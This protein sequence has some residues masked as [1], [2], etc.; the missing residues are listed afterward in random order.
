MND[1]IMIKVVVVLGTD[2]LRQYS[3]E[4]RTSKLHSNLLAALLRY[5]NEA[6]VL[7]TVHLSWIC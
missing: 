3:A 6:T 7:V 1:A 4:E 5:D 2:Y